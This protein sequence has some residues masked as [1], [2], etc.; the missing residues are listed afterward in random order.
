[1]PYQAFDLISISFQELAVFTSACTNLW[2]LA[3]CWSDHSKMQFWSERLV[4]W[5][6]QLDLHLLGFFS[7]ACF[8]LAKC[9]RQFRAAWKITYLV[10]RGENMLVQHWCSYYPLWGC[11]Q[12]G[13]PWRISLAIFFFILF[14]VVVVFINVELFLK[15]ELLCRY[16]HGIAMNRRDPL[17]F[18]QCGKYLLNE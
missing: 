9:W 2:V 1:M 4:E 18:L 5:E 3:V 13:N 10:V 6:L 7:V 12:F 15:D 8:H 16:F 11:Q 17:V 14:V